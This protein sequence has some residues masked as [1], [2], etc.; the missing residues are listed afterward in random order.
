MERLVRIRDLKDLPSA[1]SVFLD[2]PDILPL[3]EPEAHAWTWALQRVPEL[4][5]DPGWD[6]NLPALEN[7]VGANRRGL[8]MSFE[9]LRRFAGRV[10]QVIW[11]EFIAAESPSA[12]PTGSADGRTV[13]QSAVAGLAAIDSS[14]W[15]VGGPAELIDRVSERFDAVDE[16][17]VGEWLRADG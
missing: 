12:L 17:P 3:F 9:D 14:F 16:M 4:T 2:L 10:Q 5:A 11:G 1:I 13:G 15:L 7:E 6:F 8:Q